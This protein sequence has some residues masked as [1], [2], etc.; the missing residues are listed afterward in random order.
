M[1]TS[2]TPSPPAPTLLERLL[3]IRRGFG[4]DADGVRLILRSGLRTRRNW[5]LPIF[6]LVLAIALLFSIKFGIDDPVG[7]AMLRAVLLD[8]AIFLF[9]GLSGWNMARLWRENADQLEE[10][11]L[12]PLPPAVIGATLLTPMVA[13]WLVMIVVFGLVDGLTPVELFDGLQGG[14]SRILLRAIPVVLA[15][16]FVAVPMTWY[17][18]ESTRLAHWMFVVHALPRG[19]GPLATLVNLI[20]IVSMVWALWCIGLMLSVFTVL[21]LAI[22]QDILG[23]N[24]ASMDVALVLAP[25]PGLVVLAA[26]KRAICRLYE[27]AFVRAWLLRQWGGIGERNPS[28][29]P[30]HHLDILP[31]WEAYYASQEE[32][33]A[34]VPLHRRRAGRHFAAICKRIA[35]QQGCAADEVSVRSSSGSPSPT[36]DPRS[37]P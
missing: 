36:P 9:A 6:G 16:L 22:A 18:F 11:A 31:F 1:N 10:L 5:V 4:E 8:L 3:G 26:A 13:I 17:H 24:V 15:A 12:S 7:R 19:A 20:V 34:N 27:R 28:A 2:P 30:R 25:W 35:D 33:R 37:E 29:P 23:R 21:P 14:T 32:E